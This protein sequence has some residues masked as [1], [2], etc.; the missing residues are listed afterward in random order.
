MKPKLLW[1]ELKRYGY[2]FSVKR[3]ILMYGMVVAFAIVCGKFFRLDHMYLFLL[4]LWCACL[5]PFF[6]RNLYRNRYGQ[7]QFVEIN[8]YME[9]FLYSFQKSGKILVTLKD[10][11]KLFANGVMHTR[12]QE[13]IAYIED[14][15]DEDYVEKRAL[16]MIER[17]YPIHHVAMIHR[18]ALQ[19]EEKGGEYGEAIRL[20]LDARRMWADRS[21]ELLKEKKRKRTQ[22]L[23]SV[24]VSLLL[25]S[26]FV[27][28]AERV[29]LSITDFAIVKV[30]TLLT[31]LLDLWIFYVADRKLSMESMDETYDEKELLRQYEKVKRSEEKKHAELGTRIAK[32][33]VSRALQKMFPQWLLEVSLLLQSENV[34]VAIMESYDEAPVL[35][36]PALREL[37][38][39]LQLRPTDMEPYLEFL[40]EYALP[41]VQSSM[42]MLYALSE[43]TGGN[44]NNQISD[45][46]RRNQL[47]LDQAQKMK[48]ED[49]LG[50]LYALFL[51]PQL[52]GGAKMLVDMGML[53]YAMM[54][55]SALGV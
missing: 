7:R 35:M 39:K 27:Y 25:C 1:D 52:T 5:F 17:E 6:L 34:Q 16:A 38:Q 41:E 48:N 30:V 28:V 36:K 40:Q 49:A 8:S 53:F 33:N 47:L 42:K 20:M 23:I 32:K 18:F 9:Q 46:I 54:A 37:I 31:L 13:A 10:V 44:A 51:A 45:I 12:I 2:V 19:V 24:L 26:V 50:G 43:G 14:T 22:I 15:Y 21:Y 55:T 4:C 3:G 11:E 29:S